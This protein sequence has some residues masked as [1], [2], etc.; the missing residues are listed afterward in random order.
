MNFL[1]QSSINRDNVLLV[2]SQGERSNR[3]IKRGCCRVA[4]RHIVVPEQGPTK[5]HC[6][7]IQDNLNLRPFSKPASIGTSSKNLGTMVGKCASLSQSIIN[8]YNLFSADHYM[9][10]LITHQFTDEDFF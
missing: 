8:D 2:S 5:G 7:K 10:L 6:L 9:A 1:P 3:E 4:G